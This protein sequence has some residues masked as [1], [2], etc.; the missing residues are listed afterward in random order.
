[1][2]CP[3]DAIVQRVRDIEQR[4]ASLEREG[5]GAAHDLEAAP[6]ALTPSPRAS[7]SHRMRALAL[8]VIECCTG[9]REKGG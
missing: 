3:A 9:K 2:M 1:M 5:G 7:K 8:H 6:D 4:L